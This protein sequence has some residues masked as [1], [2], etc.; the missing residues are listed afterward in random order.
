MAPRGETLT[1]T[2]RATQQ[3]RTR[4]ARANA[5]ARVHRAIAA[6]DLKAAK[7]RLAELKRI[8]APTKAERDA[9]VKAMQ[10]HNGIPSKFPK[11]TSSGRRHA[12]AVM[13]STTRALVGYNAARAAEAAQ[14]KAL[15]DDIKNSKQP[16][17]QAWAKA[18]LAA[19][20]AKLA[21]TNAQIKTASAA[22]A[23]A[24]KTWR[25]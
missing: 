16:A 18:Q 20:N 25:G 24:R 21:A 3:T 17:T 19:T 13:A 4:D 9:A 22:Y 11:G 10:K 23:S 7:T 14:A 12:A 1:L 15:R 6:A 8:K 2:H 5:V